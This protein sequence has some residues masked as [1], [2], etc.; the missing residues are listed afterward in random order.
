MVTLRPAFSL[1]KGLT[2]PVGSGW[3]VGA[4]AGDG[5]RVGAGRPAIQG[6]AATRAMLDRIV[7]AC[8]SARPKSA[9]PW[10]S[11]PCESA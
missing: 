5:P 1:R 11:S 6:S 4:D 7:V 2:R 8:V 9:E 10:R 3:H